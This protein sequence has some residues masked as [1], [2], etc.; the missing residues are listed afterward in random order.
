LGIGIQKAVNFCF[1]NNS[2]AIA[3]YIAEKRY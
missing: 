2:N 3:I 1:E